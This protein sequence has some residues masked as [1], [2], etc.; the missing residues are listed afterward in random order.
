MPIK[1]IAAKLG[2]DEVYYFSKVY[3]RITGKNPS[4]VR[5]KG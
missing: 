1:D 5:G 4:A 2:F 3:K